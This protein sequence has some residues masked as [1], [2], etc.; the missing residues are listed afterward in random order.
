MEAVLAFDSSPTRLLLAF[1]GKFLW[2][3]PPLGPG[4][5]SWNPDVAG[6]GECMLD[7]QGD[8]G[9]EAIP[10]QPFSSADPTSVRRG[11]GFGFHNTQWP[12]SHTVGKDPPSL[13]PDQLPPKDRGRVECRHRMPCGSDQAIPPCLGPELL[14]GPRHWGLVGKCMSF[15][16]TGKD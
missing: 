11:P 1:D 14:R 16:A 6:W 13:C 7:P 2:S 12:L 5:A 10:L 8:G 15:P 3:L 4:A 9:R